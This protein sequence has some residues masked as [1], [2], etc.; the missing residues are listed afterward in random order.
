MVEVEVCNGCCL[1]FD[2]E[3]A[4]TEVPLS[5]ISVSCFCCCKVLLLFEAAVVAAVPEL[6]L[7]LPLETCFPTREKDCERELR[8][9]STKSGSVVVLLLVLVLVDFPTVAPWMVE[10]MAEGIQLGKS[11]LGALFL[12]GIFVCC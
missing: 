5:F 7:L 2:S 9:R 10:A 8:M 12:L 6:M 11:V 1:R 3:T 4:P